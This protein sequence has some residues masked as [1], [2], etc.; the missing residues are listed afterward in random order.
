MNSLNDFS[1]INA[2]E[3]HQDMIGAVYEDERDCTKPLR[4]N[5][6]DALATS[7]FI[8]LENYYRSDFAVDIEDGV[9]PTVSSPTAVT[10]KDATG[11][12]ILNLLE[13]VISHT[14]KLND[15][16]RIS[17]SGSISESV[18]VGESTTSTSGPHAKRVSS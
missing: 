2:I 15:S 16:N 11:A 17:E 10:N 3:H 14:L 12:H 5:E 1:I 6:F 18:A 8:E 9:P 7:H 13:N 4:N